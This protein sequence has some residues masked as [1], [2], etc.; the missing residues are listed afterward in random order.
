MSASRPVGITLVEL[1]VVLVIIGVLATTTG[2]AF[3]NARLDS[4][5]SKQASLNALRA[6]AI[7]DECPVQL[8][9]GDP[10]LQ[11]AVLVLPDGRVIGDGIDP[12]TGQVID[13]TR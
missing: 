4:K 11:T 3:S 1:L 12:L 10:T 6:R 2:L 9:H 13:A 8:R 7:L 5:P